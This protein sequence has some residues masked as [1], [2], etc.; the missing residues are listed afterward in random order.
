[1][2]VVEPRRTEFLELV[3]LDRSELKTVVVDNDIPQNLH[4]L[5]IFGEMSQNS[6]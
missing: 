1:M 4:I 3:D 5:S 2:D 6:L